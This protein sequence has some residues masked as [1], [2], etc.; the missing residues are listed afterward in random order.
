MKERALS[1]VIPDAKAEGAVD[2]HLFANKWHDLEK[3]VVRDLI[4]AGTRPTVVTVRRSG[5]LNAMS[6]CCR[7][8]MDRLFF[9]GGKPRRSS[10]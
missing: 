4:L 2:V 9:S 1:E 5:T 6:A 8:R 10:P 7:E 3:Q